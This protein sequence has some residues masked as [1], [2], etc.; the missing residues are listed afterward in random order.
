MW[1]ARVV[2]ILISL[3]MPMDSGVEA[4]VSNCVSGDHEVEME[5]CDLE[6]EKTM[7]DEVKEEEVEVEE[8]E[9]EEVQEGD[10]VEEEKESIVEIIDFKV[11]NMELNYGIAGEDVLRLKHFLKAKG[12]IDVAEGYYFDTK[13]REAVIKYQSDNGL[14][15]DGVVGKNTY[16]KINEDMK[17]S[18]ISIPRLEIIFPSEVPNGNWIVINKDNN[19]LY[20]IRGM[21]VL[22][23]YSVGTGK[24]PQ[25]TPEGKFTIVTKIVNPY[26][27][28]AGRYKPVSG[29]APNN[30]L[31]KRWM[32]L[33]IKGGSVYGIHGNSDER[34]IGR[35]ISLGCIRMFNRDAEML[36]DL[37]DI[38]IP[39]WIGNEK[40]LQEYG[41]LFEYPI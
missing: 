35:Y 15:V 40:K 24:L 27:G 39:V 32:G 30:P 37:I 34:S 18:N 2:L 3:S 33:S 4:R 7:E 25:Y 38:G 13:T 12:Y 6:V 5:S 41:I 9:V 20:H 16:A 1:V 14:K 11:D 29:G 19:T 10:D 17:S 8:I 26:W 23:S 22:N 31:G 36:Y 28:G 21:E